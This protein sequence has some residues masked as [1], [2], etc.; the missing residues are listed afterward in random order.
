MGSINYIPRNAILGKL[1]HFV[2]GN[3]SNAKLKGLRF[4]PFMEITRE[5]QLRIID[6]AI[7]RLGT[8][9]HAF[10]IGTIKDLRRGKRPMVSDKWQKITNHIDGKPNMIPVCGY[11]GAGEEII[12]YD[13]HAIGAG[14]DEVE[15][16][17]GMPTDMVAVIVRGDSME[18]AFEDGSIIFYQRMTDGVPPDCI[19]RPCVVKLEN[20]GML[21]KKVRQGSKPNLYHLISKNP[22]HPPLVDQKLLWA[23]RVLFIKPR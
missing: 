8:N 22:L 16:P 18:P 3:S 23:S 12:C 1:P 14:L 15:V 11:V 6:D 4:I 5:N 19:G 9:Q 2:K 21:L 17:P 20:E 7:E 10:P 13:D